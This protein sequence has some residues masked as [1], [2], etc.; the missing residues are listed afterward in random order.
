VPYDSYSG[1]F[2]HHAGLQHLDAKGALAFV[3][4]RH[5]LLNGDLDRTHRQQAF[6]DSVIHQLKTEGALTDFFK[7]DGL[8][9]AA[10]QYVITDKGWDLKS[11]ATDMGAFTG[12]NLSFQ[13]AKVDGY[14]TING[15]AA[16]TITPAVIQQ[17]VQVA[18]NPAPRTGKSA[19]KKQLTDPNPGLTTVV[20]ENG[21]KVQGLAGNV[22]AA[23]AKEGYKQ[24]T[25]GDTT[26]PQPATTVLYG[27]GAA[28]SGQV[29]AAQFG[30]T[31][32]ASSQVP[33]GT[34]RILLGPGVNVAQITAPAAGSGSGGAPATTP[35]PSS[36][37]N[38]AGG[39]VKVP[40][41]GIPCVD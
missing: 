38:P 15:Q 28:T 34:V 12:K 36:T 41:S 10:N 21:T 24:G 5:G 16:N 1:F 6:I 39:A 26:T 18:F 19:G 17:Q 27:S 14:S 3:R 23:L 2:A 33:A 20:V 13:T 31:A 40:A 25:V 8:L 37:Y 32:Q 22:S 11:F 29:I 35:T 9:S 7:L 4:Q 30:V